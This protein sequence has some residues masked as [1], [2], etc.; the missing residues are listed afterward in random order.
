MRRQPSRG[1]PDGGPDRDA[2]GRPGGCHLSLWCLGDLSADGNA[3]S[4]A[5]GWCQLM[6]TIR[7]GFLLFWLGLA[8]LAVADPGAEVARG[9]AGFVRWYLYAESPGLVLGESTLGVLPEAPSGGCLLYTSPS[10][11]DRG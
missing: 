7:Y 5:F 1:S 3:W 6:Q 4:A 8:G 10:P 9:D 2:L 11:R